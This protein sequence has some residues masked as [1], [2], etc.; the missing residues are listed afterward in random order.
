MP[1]ITIALIAAN[2]IAFAW[3]LASGADAM[4]PTP[5]K[6]V[7]L[8]GNLP[9][10]TL[11]GQWWRLGS[12][13]FLH[14]GVLHIGMNMFCLWQARIAEAAFGRAAYATIYV[15]SGLIG[16]IATALHAPSN[17]VSVGASGA[18]F[19]VY[20]AFF[21]LLIV[22]R[23]LMPRDV[24]ERVVRS[25]AMFLG[26]NLAIGLS[27]KGID[28]SAHVGGLAA[29]ALGG[30]ALVVRRPRGPTPLARTLALAA[31]GLAIVVGVLVV[32]HGSATP[33]TPPALV[34][35]QDLQS[36]EDQ[37]LDRANDALDR[38]ERGTL[39]DA[40]AAAQVERDALGPWKAMRARV[41]AVTP[42]PEQAEL[43]REVLTYVASRQTELEALAAYL[44]TPNDTTRAAFEAAKHQVA[45]DQAP[46]R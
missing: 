39:A 35:F 11:G 14:A 21:A 43:W 32:K 28:M 13:M 27:V 36:T 25:M 33:P 23:A 29:G 34:A 2:A 7:E 42:A 5:G 17:V 45:A 46:L 37:V 31:A 8:G 9:A 15:V 4:S 10:L 24:W 18:V 19:G 6:L 12:A 26:L 22:R 30:L 38:H 3:E 16:G 1:W 41:E 40:D 44:R 20:G